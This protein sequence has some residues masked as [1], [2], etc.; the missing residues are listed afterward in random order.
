MKIFFLVFLLSLSALALDKKNKK[1][2]PFQ[3]RIN[4]CFIRQI[5]VKNLVNLKQLYLEIVRQYQLRASET[6]Y[7]EVIYAVGGE[8]RKLR[9]EDGVVNIYRVEADE[10]VTLISS[11]SIA[12][13]GSNDKMRYKLRTPEA[14]LDELL[15][16]AEIKFDFIK[17]TEFRSAQLI[18]NLVWDNGVIQNLSAQFGSENRRLECQKKSVAD[19]C[20]CKH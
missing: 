14:R 11:E 3:E 1:L 15:N 6:T 10:K 12:Q 16:R 8:K 20:D 13:S 9:F 18:L 7:R 5:D 19:I 2:T 4:E 17:T